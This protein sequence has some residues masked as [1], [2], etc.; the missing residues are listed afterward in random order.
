[1]WPWLDR[2]SKSALRGVSIAMRRQVDGLIE[3]VASPA[4]GFSPDALTSALLRWA[5]TTDLTLLNVGGASD[6]A[7]LATT[8]AM[9]RLTSLTVRQVGRMARSN[10][11]VLCCAVH[12]PIPRMH[13]QLW[14]AFMLDACLQLPSGYPR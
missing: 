10:G 2:N 5:R 11:R 14:H 6:L 7:P 1:M 4:S 12:M 8:T 3:V 9:A 13:M